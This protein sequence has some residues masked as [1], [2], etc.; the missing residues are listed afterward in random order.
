MWGR[1]LKHHLFVLL[2]KPSITCVIG[3]SRK[4][5]EHCYTCLVTFPGTTNISPKLSQDAPGDLM[6]V[7]EAGGFV[8]IQKESLAEQGTGASSG[9][10]GASSGAEEDKKIRETFDVGNCWKNWNTF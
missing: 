7:D 2:R 10:S 8:Q 3:S 9:G 1:K 6:V 4:R 5:D